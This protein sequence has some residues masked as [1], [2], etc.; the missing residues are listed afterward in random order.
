M[1]K[2]FIPKASTDQNVMDISGLVITALSTS[3]K[4]A[5]EL[6]SYATRVK[7]AKG[8]I[9]ALSNELFGLIGALEHLKLQEARS[10]EDRAGSLGLPE[11]S[12]KRPSADYI[13]QAA[14]EIPGP[15]IHKANV[16]LVLV[17]TLDL[18]N[19]LQGILLEPKGRFHATVQLLK[20]PLKENEM[21]M[22]LKRLERV[23][24]YFVLSLVTDEAFVSSFT[25]VLKQALP[26]YFVQ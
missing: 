24:T 17:Q 21:Q 1:Q 3:F 15:A 23:K 16:R 8:D 20:W 5:S 25:V 13:G 11:Y 19:E 18:L 4:F 7:G 9:E 12:E 22:Y 6:Y 2:P 10:L 26:D 14:D